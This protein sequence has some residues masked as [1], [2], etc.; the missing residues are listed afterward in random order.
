MLALFCRHTSFTQSSDWSFSQSTVTSIQWCHFWLSPPLF[1]WLVGLFAVFF[2]K[3]LYKIILSPNWQIFLESIFQVSQS[4]PLKPPPSLFPPLPLTESVRTIGPWLRL[5]PPRRG[6]LPPICG[7][8]AARVWAADT[9][10]KM[11]SFS[12]IS[13]LLQKI[14]SCKRMITSTFA[15]RKTQISKS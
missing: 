6:T 7:M 9:W 15:N 8:W 11:M 12:K 13:W 1:I 5:A 4:V 10:M 14:S 3:T 2:L